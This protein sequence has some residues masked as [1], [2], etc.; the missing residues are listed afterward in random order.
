ME[1]FVIKNIYGSILYECYAK[2]L[3]DA[4]IKAI[5]NNV[6]LRYADLPELDLNDITL[7]CVDFYGANLK[8]SN[9]SGSILKNINLSNANLYGSSFVG[10]TLYK[11]NLMDV[12]FD[13]VDL[14]NILLNNIKTNKRIIQFFGV[15]VQD[16]T[17]TYCITDDIVWYNG[18]MG[19]LKKFEDFCNISYLNDSIKLHDFY[20]ITE[21]L[22]KLRF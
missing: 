18:F 5:N 2:S 3:S 14:R 4:V 19:T 11:A 20:I 8:Y 21:S 13:H 1:L 15:E 7:N 9:F 6:S 22:N 12:D 16:E 10:T 17:I